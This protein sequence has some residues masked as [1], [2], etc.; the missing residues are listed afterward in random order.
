MMALVCFIMFM[1]GSTLLYLDIIDWPL[2]PTEGPVWM[3]HT[4]YTGI[5]KA[6]VEVWIAL[7]MLLLYPAWHLLGYVVARA[8]DEGFFLKTVSYDDV[9]SRI[10][11]KPESKFAVQRGKNPREITRDAIEA[12]GGISEYVKA[13]NKVLIKPNI[14]G[15][16]PLI[17]GSYTSIEVVDE[18]VKMVKE[19]GAE[20]FVVDS[21]MIWTK[22]EPVAE[23]QGWK[24]W[25]KNAGVKIKNLAGT[26]WVRFD[27]GSKSSIG[28]VPVSNELVK[29]D[30]II[31]VPTM[32][33]HLLTNI[34]IAMKNMYG[35][36][37][38]EAKAKFHRYGI[39]N[40]VYEVNEAFTPNLV[41]IDGTIGGEAWGP[42][43]CNPVTFETVIASNDV[44]AADAIA[45]KMIGYD[46]MVVA[47]VNKAHTEG[48]GDATIPFDLASLPY[49][50]PKDG[51][52]IK[53]EP[54]VTAFYEALCEFVLLIPGM[55]VTFDLAADFMLFGLATLP[56]FRDLT[57]ATLGVLNDV[58][59]ALFRSG[60]RGVKWV[61]EN[62]GAF[63]GLS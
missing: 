13:G 9:K 38:E 41:L 40:V 56:I 3:F 27:F 47:H 12:I 60:Y 10:R 33:T 28:K 15:G 54:L 48:L 2:P 23:A 32:K 22:F 58:F 44:V 49:S 21:D 6:S 26:R 29:A 50:H 34:T 51:N 62:L 52:W 37:P 18:I 42:L 16:N 39:E 61:Q 59:G 8:F 55:Q 25:A 45:C 57:P 31:S 30:V 24:T 35:T 7:G 43:S 53:P 11:P 20:P 4:D 5:T 36:F 46:P 1:G 14:S 19:Q 17:T 63:R